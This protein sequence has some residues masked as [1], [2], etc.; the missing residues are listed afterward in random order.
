MTEGAKKARVKS[1]TES[2]ERALRKQ[3]YI[4]RETNRSQTESAKKELR[5]ISIREQRAR[6][7]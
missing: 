4:K 5:K 3:Q 1:Q 6:E 2:H 7:C